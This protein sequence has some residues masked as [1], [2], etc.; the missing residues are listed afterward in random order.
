MSEICGIFVGKSMNSIISFVETVD[1]KRFGV[2]ILLTA[3]TTFVETGKT[4]MLLNQYL[5]D[6]HHY[7]RRNKNIDFGIEI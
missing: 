4:N 2:K 5:T 3:I 6:C 7:L 1:K